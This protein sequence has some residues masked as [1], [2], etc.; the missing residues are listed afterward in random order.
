MNAPFSWAHRYLRLPFVAALS[1]CALLGCA[2]SGQ[3]G[4]STTTKPIPLPSLAL[5]TQHP[6]PGCELKASVLNGHKGRAE[7]VAVRVANLPG[8][9][10]RISAESGG[11]PSVPGPALQPNRSL[12]QANPAASLAERIRLEYERNCFQRAEVRVRE[13]LLQLQVA[14][15][16]TVRAVKSAERSDRY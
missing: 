12:A 13:K 5:V 14:V 7:G 1:G 3:Q 11:P 8:E 10:S 9:R 2:H 6:E 16:K 4:S 15:R